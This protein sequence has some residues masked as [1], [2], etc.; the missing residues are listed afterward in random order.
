[1]ARANLLYTTSRGHYTLHPFIKPLVPEL[2]AQYP[3]QLKFEIAHIL[4]TPDSED[5]HSSNPSDTPES[6]TPNTPH[7][8][9]PPDTTS[10]LASQIRIAHNLT[11]PSPTL[12]TNPNT[13]TYPD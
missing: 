3:H 7:S 12:L 4:P 6:S 5:T 2:L 9:Q 1:M 13:N 10:N 8:T 11:P